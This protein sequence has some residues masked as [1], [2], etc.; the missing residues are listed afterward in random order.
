MVLGIL[1]D[2][3][4]ML[5][6]FCRMLP[7]AGCC[8]LPGVRVSG[9]RRTARERVLRELPLGAGTGQCAAPQHANCRKLGVQA[10]SPP[11]NSVTKLP[12]VAEGE[13][14][15]PQ[16]AAPGAAMQLAA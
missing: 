16:R 3:A 9:V 4:A 12:G 15:I 5:P 10:R 11:H 2:A 8:I 6:R 1:P 13:V 7:D 14:T